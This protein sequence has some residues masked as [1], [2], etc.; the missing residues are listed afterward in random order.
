M[1]PLGLSPTQGLSAG[2]VGYF[3]ASMKNVA[4]TRVG[5]KVTGVENPTPEALRGYRKAQ[6]MVYCGTYTED[7]S[8]YP[9]FRV[10]LDDLQLRAPALSYAPACSGAMGV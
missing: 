9:A 8:K 2:E 4:D 5:D 3:T 6:P 1:H 7:A 10:D